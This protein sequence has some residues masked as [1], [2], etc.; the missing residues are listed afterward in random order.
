MYIQ[1]H[2]VEKILDYCKIDDFARE[3]LT[4]ALNQAIEQEKIT[5]ERRARVTKGTYNTIYLFLKNK[6]N[7]VPTCVFD[8]TNAFNHEYNADVSPQSIGSFL[9]RM[10]FKNRSN[11]DGSIDARMDAPFSNFRTKVVEGRRYYWV[12]E[13]IDQEEIRRSNPPKYA[14][15]IK[16]WGKAYI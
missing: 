1:K 8:L 14:R 16:S 11:S 15:S 6:M 5:A 13:A 9:C 10:A 4:V 12:G 7:G 3:R 2:D